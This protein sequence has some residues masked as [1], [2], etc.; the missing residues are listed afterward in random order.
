MGETQRYAYGWD[1]GLMTITNGGD[2]FFWLLVGH[3][4]ADFPL[5]GDFLARGKDHTTEFGRQWWHIALPA[6]AMIHAGAVALVTHST[7]LGMVELFAHS[8]IDYL[9]CSNRITI[10][11]DQICHIL[12]KIGYVVFLYTRPI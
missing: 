6:H 2:I 5:Q 12:C 7:S 3:A 4:L 1:E 8:F 10:E 9:K 11:R